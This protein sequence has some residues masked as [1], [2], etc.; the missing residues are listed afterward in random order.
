M[1]SPTRVAPAVY[2]VIKMRSRAYRR[3]K[4]YSK[5]WRRLK[6]DRNQHYDDLT[7]A[8]YTKGRAM[9]RFK[10]QPQSCSRPWCCGNMRKAYGAT[11]QERRSEDA[12]FQ[13][14]G[15]QE[16]PLPLQED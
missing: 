15:P 2:G 8:C 7:C 10:E 3:H 11:L 6:E 13:H 4:A 14:C 12:Y 1:I 16:A 5:M 9:S